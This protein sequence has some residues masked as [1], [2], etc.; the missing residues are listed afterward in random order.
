MP[1]K[2]IGDK[3]LGAIDNLT[4]LE[5]VTAVGETKLGAGGRARFDGDAKVM[6]TRLRLLDGDASTRL[7]EAF[8]TGPYTD[9]RDFHAAQVAR[10]MEIV[11]QNIAAL[12]ELYRLYKLVAADEGGAPAKPGAGG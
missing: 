4:T 5:I 8:V 1:E 7:D 11:K 9:L 10:G 3:I 12:G 6:A 2:T